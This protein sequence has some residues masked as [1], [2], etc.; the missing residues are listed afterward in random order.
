[1]ARATG[2]TVFLTIGLLAAMVNVALWTSFQHLLPAQIRASGITLADAGAF[3][4]LAAGMVLAATPGWWLSPGRI[5]WPLAGAVLLMALAAWR[6][7]Y[8]ETLEQIMEVLLWPI[9]R[10][11]CRGPGLASFPMRGP[12]LVV[13]NHSSYF[14][15]LW[16]A[17][18]VPR[19][20]TPM[21]T[22]AFYDLPGLHWLMTTIVK[23]I[24]VE[25]STFRR[26]APELKEGI[27][28]LDRG[29]C[30]VIF[31]EGMLR[32][33][34]DRPVRQFG[35]GVWHILRERPTVP[36]VV[37]WI[38]GGWGSYFSYFNGPPMTNKSID[39]WLRI[40]IAMQEPEVID[41]S[42]LVDQRRTRTYLRQRCIDAR[43]YLGL[44]PLVDDD[45]ATDKPE[46]E[47]DE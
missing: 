40:A 24:R 32:R 37:C 8:R 38:D 39:W 18:F 13:A 5:F 35:Q 25:A 4:I 36:I 12:V 26:E 14:D 33:R 20:L 30:L 45:A 47:E 6:F 41:S 46:A 3:A 42:I 21:M 23:A 9:Y 27:A 16:L 43:K 15:P 2:P 34:A 1:M 22:S 10:I 44:E 19:R 17:K 28:A 11:R 7:Y 29:E 31:P